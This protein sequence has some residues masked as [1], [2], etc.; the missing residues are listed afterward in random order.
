MKKMNINIDIFGFLESSNEN[1]KKDVQSNKY[2]IKSFKGELK[3][4]DVKNNLQNYRYL[5][6][7]SKFDGL[8][9][10]IF[11]AVESNIIPII[12]DQIL[13]PIY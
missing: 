7:P 9:V 2:F 6:L 5:I 12:S 1:Y 8:P 10:I 4:S 3:N 11:E 13:L